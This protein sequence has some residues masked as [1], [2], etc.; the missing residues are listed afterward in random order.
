MARSARVLVVFLAALGA[1]HGAAAQD[2]SPSQDTRT[3]YPALLANSYFSINVGFI[4]YAY[5]EDKK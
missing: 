3:Q 5:V 4:D 1:V 2:V